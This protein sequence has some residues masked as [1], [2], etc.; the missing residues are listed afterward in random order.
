MK[1][2]VA[3]VLVA[4]SALSRN[5][6]G[7]TIFLDGFFHEINELRDGAFRSL[8]GRKFHGLVHFGRV[9]VC[10]GDV[11]VLRRKAKVVEGE[12]GVNW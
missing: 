1:S 2:K 9:V 12:P 4:V 5:V 8:E 7:T 11:Q 3:F 6:A 10:K